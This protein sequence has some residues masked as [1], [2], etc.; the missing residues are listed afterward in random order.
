MLGLKHLKNERLADTRGFTLIEIAIVLVIIG[1][2]IGA[3]VKGKDLIQSGKQKKFYTKNLKAW[4]LAV[5]TYYDRTGFALGDGTANGGTATTTDGRFDNVSGANFGN[6]NGIDAKLKA[7]G[8][9]VPTSNTANSGQFSFKGQYSG[10][11]TIT[12]YLY[13]L[14]SH[15][16]K[17]YSNAL[18]FTSMPTDLAIA[19]DTMVDG[20]IDARK[21][22]FRRYADNATPNDGT[23]PD[24]TVTTTVNAQYIMDVP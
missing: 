1:L 2:I 9:T 5:L 6:T 21:G 3:V 22:T 24:A 18:Y 13:Y 14:Y 10:T 23:W 20:Q 12:M 15:T 11:Q 7:V 8:L 16:Q 4:E 19:L 17:K